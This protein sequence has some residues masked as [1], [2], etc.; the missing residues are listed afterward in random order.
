MDTIR[1][2]TVTV[3]SK[4]DTLLSRITATLFSGITSLA[5]WIR[6][7]S[8]KDAGTSGMIAA[9][10]EINT[11]GTST[12]DGTTDNLEAIR[13][14]GGGGGGGGTVNIVVEDRSI[15]VV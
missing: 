3:E 4:V 5:D 1:D 9:Q 13:D 8:R 7:I 6:R 11:G 15:T 2:K 10:T 14:A 12:F